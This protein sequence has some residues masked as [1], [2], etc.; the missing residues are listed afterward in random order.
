VGTDRLAAR[1]SLIVSVSVIDGDK[2]LD[3]QALEHELSDSF[4]PDEEDVAYSPMRP[5]P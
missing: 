1:R 2:W 4:D 3:Q 5:P